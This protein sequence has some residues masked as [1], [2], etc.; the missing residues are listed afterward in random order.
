MS[1]L[2]ITPAVCATILF[3]L[4]SGPLLAQGESPSIRLTSVPGTAFETDEPSI[5][6]EGSAIA[7]AGLANIHWVNQFEQRGRGSWSA[8]AQTASWT[9]ADI[10]LRPGINLLTVTAVD[11]ANR[12]ASL[13]LAVNRK[14]SPGALPQPPLKIDT[15][16]WQNRQVTY[17]LWKGHE[18][19]EGDII[20]D[21]SRSSK[22]V[23]PTSSAVKGAINPDGLGISYTSQLWPIEGAVHVVPYVRTDTNSNLTNAITD[24]NTTFAGLIQ[25]APRGSETSY[26][27]I[28][29]EAG[30]SGEG[31]SDVGVSATP[32]NTL[33]CGSGCTEATWL[34]E[35]GHTVGLLHEHQRPDRATYITLNLANADLPNVPGNFT[36]FAFDYQTF[37]LYDYAS[38]MHYGA[39]DFS[40]AGLPV[41]ESIPAGIPL[42]NITG[43]S[44]GDV[45][46]IKRMY[47]A[48]PSQVTVT[49]NPTGLAIIVDGTTYTAPQT[50]SLTLHSTH[51]LNLPADPQLTNPADGSTYGF[52]AW[53]DKKARSHSITI[54]PGAGT[55][56]APATV[57]A[58]TVYEAN[59]IRYQPFAYLSPAAF[60][61][62]SGTVRAAP[63]AKAIFGGS[64]YTDRTLVKL[65]L[66]KNA[67]YGFFDWF[68]LPYPPSDNPK[69]FYIQTPVT[70]AQAV[71]VPTT[72]AGASP[73][74]IVGETLTGPNT[75]NP[76]LA[77]TVDGSFAFLPTGFTPFYDGPTWNGGT[78]HTID[79]DQTQ[80][81][82]T[83]N[84]YYNFNSWSDGKAI[85]HK[86]TQPLT[87]SKAV[88]ASFTPFYASYTAPINSCAG[89][90]ATSPAGVSY[91][92][93]PA[94]LFYEDGTPVT[95]TATPAAGMVFVGWGGSLSGST[96]PTPATPIDDQFV[97]IGNFNLTGTSVPLAITSL[98]PATATA[99]ATG[100]KLTINGTGFTSGTFV[101]WNGSLRTPV[102]VSPTELTVQLQAGDL[103]NPGG[104]DL[105]MGNS[106]GICAVYAEA[107][108][109]VK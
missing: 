53:N 57:P 17:Q 105:F 100:L 52:G 91:P 35:M 16:T 9:V 61:S 36:L 96:N 82:V 80:S 20:L 103:A 97:P 32:P 44:A 106:T 95:T 19:V 48:A 76:G 72:G 108:F 68:N 66:T 99:R 39:F 77:G 34:H 37:G 90:V 60:P 79:V 55:L 43:Y 74:T 75:W 28:T 65:T 58:V 94:F 84:V 47:G 18:V 13:H 63:A 102:F 67:G 101:Q 15:G 29:V 31:H 40:K 78:S 6:L 73:V 70:Q 38:V 64:F 3:A 71:L 87:G 98:V 104:Q 22:A 8:G 4:L 23:G 14:P 83:T 89:L 54:A 88:T 33:D 69:S 62:G 92:L 7:A 81:P 24:F 42:G 25:F 10:P 1:P 49:T 45:D 93:N 27:N 59:F 12:S 21:L 51:T 11:A 86:I 107:S 30:G 56:T 85:S 5:T 2:R 26:V 109:I 46:Q 50:F 41:L